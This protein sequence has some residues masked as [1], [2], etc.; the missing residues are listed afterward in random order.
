V[1]RF[2]LIVLLLAVLVTPLAAQDT[3]EIEFVHIFGSEGDTRADVIREIADDFEAL[4]GNE[5]I[6]I[7]IR[8]TSTDYTE[9]FNAAL[10]AADQ[11]NAPHIVQVE[12]GLTQLAADSGFFLPIGEL[13]SEEQLA[14][15]EGI[16]P[17]VANYYR[18]GDTLWSMPWNSSNPV[19]Y[20]NK[21]ITDVLQIEI[22]PTDP[23]TFSEFKA[24]CD[25]IQ[26]VEMLIQAVN[27]GYT[28]CA[29]WPM[30][31]WFPEQWMA[32]QNAVVANNENGRDGR[33]TEMFYTSPEMQQIVEW[34]AEMTA[35]GHFTYT[36][37]QG[38]YNGEGALF[39]TGA[40]T[41]HI[42]STA[43]I[44]L[45][46][47]GFAGAGAELGIAPLPVPDEEA[48]NGVTMGG[49]SLWVTA[50]HSDEETQV[51]VDFIFYLTNAENDQRWHQGSGYFPVREASI[52]ALTEGGL[53]ATPDGIPYLEDGSVAT[54]PEEVPV[55]LVWLQSLA[56]GQL[57]LGVD[58]PPA[59]DAQ[60]VSWFGTFPFFR[61][62]VDQLANSN[63]N[64]ATQGA[65][66]GPSTEVRTALTDAIQSV[67][68]S[69]LNEDAS[70]VSVTDALEAAKT[71]ADAALAAYNAVI[72]E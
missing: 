27:A 36:G 18:V 40:T 23:M 53:W 13:A 22:S 70:P 58:G 4:P 69:I 7:V 47:A 49:A 63:N 52:E 19:L 46:V 6:D 12:E 25:Q 43:G 3:I 35:D 59:D 51:A 9:V 50:G 41:F 68:N 14:S 20:Y 31:S 33:A 66:I 2:A 38:D 57:A 45:F 29:N 1:K 34:W 72:G 16:L 62:A 44:T 11:G 17:V 55:E 10:L 26:S 42:N 28:H 71:R 48:D 32:M 56:Q 24:V 60:P 30:V 8:S 15:V 61:I 5:N 39:G 21:T 37:A 67:V 64:V 65:I 54:V